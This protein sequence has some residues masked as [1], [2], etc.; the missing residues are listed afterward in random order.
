MVVD[1]SDWIM[2]LYL[3]QILAINCDPREE[4]EYEMTFLVK[5]QSLPHIPLQ[6]CFRGRLVARGTQRLTR[7]LAMTSNNFIRIYTQAVSCRRF[8]SSGN[9]GLKYELMKLCPHEGWKRFFYIFSVITVVLALL[10]C[11]CETSSCGAPY[12]CICSQ[13]ALTCAGFARIV[14]NYTVLICG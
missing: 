7:V 6:Q 1:I 14:D 5:A 9:K 13:T 10:L 2:F 12:H 8:T 3:V 4:L 11:D